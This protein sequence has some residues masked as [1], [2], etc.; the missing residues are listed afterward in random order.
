[1]P[2]VLRIG[3]YR[4]FF[5]S[6]ESSEPPH[7]HVEAGDAHA[8][9]WLAPVRLEKNDGY[10]PRA[11]RRLR[12]L[13]VQHEPQILERWHEHLGEHQRDPRN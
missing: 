11:L 13:T 10:N 9:I 4:F 5:W 2:T 8:K 12:E 3:P 1:V 6:N 7:V